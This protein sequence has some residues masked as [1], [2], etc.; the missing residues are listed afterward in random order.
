VVA[1]RGH[2]HLAFKQSELRFCVSSR[3]A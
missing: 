2:H 3:L 1:E